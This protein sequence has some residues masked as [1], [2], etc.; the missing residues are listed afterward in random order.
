MSL[1]VCVFYTLCLVYFRIRVVSYNILADIYADQD[2]SRDVL[3]NYCPAYALSMDYR[4]P[5]IIK[6][7][8]GSDCN[9]VLLNKYLQIFKYQ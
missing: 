8:K 5:L 9:S 6:E 7:L 1:F 4:K 3:F 2:F